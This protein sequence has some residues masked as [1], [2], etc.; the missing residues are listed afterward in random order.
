VRFDTAPA[1][2]TFCG[3][4]RS[5]LLILPVL[6]LSSAPGHAMGSGPHPHLGIAIPPPPV[7]PPA[8][9]ATTAAA[10]LLIGFGSVGAIALCAWRADHIK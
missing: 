8:T 6:V 4:L 7:T 5:L 10:F 9:P 1:S 2:T 3:V